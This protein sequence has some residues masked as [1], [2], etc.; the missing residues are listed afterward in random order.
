MEDKERILTE[1]YIE[2]C[3]LAESSLKQ[4]KFNS[5]V[6]LFFKAISAAADIFILKKVGFVPSSH[7]HRFRI[8]QEKFSELY[9]L[10]DK[11]FPFY[12]QSYTYKMTEEA[13]QILKEDAKRIKEMG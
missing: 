1:N 6:T 8:A 13:A 2:Y 11:D 3:E 4:K 7:T 9:D 10:L 12:Q 5:S